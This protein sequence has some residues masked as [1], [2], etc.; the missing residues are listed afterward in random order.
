MTYETDRRILLGSAAAFAA[1][2]A[3]AGR[4]NAMQKTSGTGG[5]A[6]VDGLRVYY[7]LHGGSPTGGT[8]PMVLIGG[9]LQTI[10][11]DL[12]KTVIPRLSAARPVIAIEPQAHGHT[13]DR[14]GAPI[15]LDRMAD[16]V[17][18]VLAHL[19]VAKAHLCGFS[20]GGMICTAV[21][22]RHPKIAA[23]LSALAVSY[24]LDG[25]QPELAKLQK[26]PTHVPSPELAALLPTEE[27]F[28]A[29]SESY[30]RNN[31]KPDSFMASVERVNAML[32]GWTGWTPKQLG[33]IAAPTL[34][35]IG[36]NDFV[37]IEHAAEMK[38]MIPGAWLAVLPHSTHMRLLDRID[39]L[40]PMIEERIAA[41]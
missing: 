2:L 27:D 35:A 6:E 34:L 15:S 7:E 4:G 28:K 38:A 24:S 40:A 19:G 41:A 10:E 25:Y 31:P 33:A 18:G 23:S 32:T 29:W 9:G 36:D 1:G 3:G 17:A 11:T 13:G 14:E 39:W 22:I 20:L 16:D 12:A 8:T 5:Y 30:A 26:D 21:A 37:R